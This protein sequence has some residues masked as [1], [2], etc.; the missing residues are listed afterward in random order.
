MKTL[1][2]LLVY[3]LLFSIVFVIF[4]PLYFEEKRVPWGDEPGGTEDSA[5]R[6]AWRNKAAHILNA[7]EQRQVLGLYEDSQSLTSPDELQCV[8]ILAP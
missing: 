6:I 2:A 7:V 4:Y 5:E 8:Y 3:C 1:A